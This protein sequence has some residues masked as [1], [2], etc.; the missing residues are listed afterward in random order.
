M[1]LLANIL[2]KSRLFIKSRPALNDNDLYF[3]TPMMTENTA[4]KRLSR[5]ELL[6]GF[7]LERVVSILSIAAEKLDRLVQYAIVQVAL[8]R[9]FGCI[10]VTKR[11]EQE[12]KHPSRKTVDE[13]T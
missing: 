13:F 11:V 10:M 1:V 4:Y 5:S 2:V 8:F 6:P 9:S 12:S 7:Y 3:K